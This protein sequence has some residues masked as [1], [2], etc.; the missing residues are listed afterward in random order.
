MQETPVQLLGRE[1]P[2][3]KGMAAHSSILTWRILMDRGTW[4]ATIHSVAK[5]Q[6]WLEWLMHSAAEHIY[7]CMYIKNEPRKNKEIHLS[8][9]DIFYLLPEVEVGQEVCGMTTMSP[10]TL[11]FK[12]SLYLGKP[13]TVEGTVLKYPKISLEVRTEERWALIP[14]MRA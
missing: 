14:L 2:L 10:T 13:S 5:C 8:I 1:D 4:R 12:F 6:T 7:I 11:S 3:E 9:W